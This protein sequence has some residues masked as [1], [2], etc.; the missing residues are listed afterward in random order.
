[1]EK[2]VANL[3]EVNHEKAV[4]FFNVYEYEKHINIIE[5][6]KKSYVGELA[7]RTCRFCNKGKPEVTFNKKAH[8]APQF[9]VNRFLL[10]AYECDT[11]NKL[12]GDLYE[13]DFANY[14]GALRPFLFFTPSKNNKNPK[15]KETVT[16]GNEEKVKI[17]IQAT[18]KRH[19]KVIYEHPFD[20][21]IVF[22]KENKK[23]SVNSNRKPYVPLHVYK[24]LLKIAVS[25]V[26]DQELA[27][28]EQTIRFLMDNSQNDKFKGYPL[29][30]VYMHSLFGKPIFSSPLMYLYKKIDESVHC[31]S[32]IFI[33]LSGNH[34]YQIF[35]PLN[36]Q[37]NWMQGKKIKLYPYPL[38]FDKSIYEK[39]LTYSSYGILMDSNE[40]K[41]GEPHQITF[42]YQEAFFNIAN[43][44][45]G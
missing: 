14:I 21:A 31:P 19:V 6:T 28:F 30:H 2:V 39:G 41:I 17:S 8:L 34:V 32:K 45:Q 11:C 42:S 36:K 20:Q 43:E 22:D 3:D 44:A 26:S 4:D 5:F 40:R 13:N 7:N 18:G 12:F 24:M 33:L 25:L 37:D 29:C 27:D 16:Y 10:S 38:L 23:F 1:M 35:I 15:Y 9:L